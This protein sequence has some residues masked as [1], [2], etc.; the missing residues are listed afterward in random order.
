ME[1]EPT[2]EMKGKGKRGKRDKCWVSVELEPTDRG[3]ERE[4]KRK[5]MLGISG[6]WTHRGDEREEK[7]VLGITGPKSAQEKGKE[8]EGKSASDT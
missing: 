2:E 4:G 1:L 8:K 6:T 3:D 7:K 5:Q